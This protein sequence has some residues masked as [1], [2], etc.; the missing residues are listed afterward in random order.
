M[1]YEN[2]ITAA[3]IIRG[4]VNGLAELTDKLTDNYK[5]GA[6]NFNKIVDGNR[7]LENI[8][9]KRGGVVC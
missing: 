3:E 2:K 6:S 5:N 1:S 7:E 8:L 9:N 4:S